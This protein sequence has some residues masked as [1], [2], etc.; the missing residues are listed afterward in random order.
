MRNWNLIGI[1]LFFALA[2]PAIAQN[3]SIKYVTKDGCKLQVRAYINKAYQPRECSRYDLEIVRLP[4]DSHQWDFTA[5]DDPNYHFPR[6]VTGDISPV[7]YGASRL[8]TIHVTLYQYDMI[9]ERVTFHNLDLGTP[10]SDPIIKTL[11]AR[12]LALKEP[13]TVTTPSGITITLPAQGQETLEKVFTG[14]FEG[15]A[16]A[17]FIQISTSPSQREAVLPE[18]PLFQKH[19]KPVTV[20]LDCAKPNSMVWYQADNTYRIIAVGLPDLKT[21]VHLDTLTLI[22]RQRVDLRS[23]PVTLTVPIDRSVGR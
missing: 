5:D 2:A 14:A 18:S 15:N 17:L 22:V 3:K 11:P 16:D 4:K 7:R 6:G 20:K 10:P 12:Y 1:V 19:G 9:E 13:V 23:V 8:A 21:V